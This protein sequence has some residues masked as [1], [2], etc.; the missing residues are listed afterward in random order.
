MIVQAMSD[1][2]GVEARSEGKNVWFALLRAPAG[3][4]AGGG[5]ACG[6]GQ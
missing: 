4:L 2:W 6:A 1:S 3:A 5:L